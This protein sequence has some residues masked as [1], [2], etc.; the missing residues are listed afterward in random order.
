MTSIA[1]RGLG[2][3]DAADLNATL[4]QRYFDLRNKCIENYGADFCNAVL[5]RNLI[6]A[7]TREDVR[8]SIPW[9][10]WMLM[11]AFVG[12]LLR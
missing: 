5:P 2:Q 9:W 12:R 10:G 11:G 7:V 1:F 8:P 4:E 3:A 6:Y